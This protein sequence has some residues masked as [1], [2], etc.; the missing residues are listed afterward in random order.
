MRE[1]LQIAGKLRKNVI[2][3][4]C[5][6]L[7]YRAAV[8]VFIIQGARLAFNYSLK[9]MGYSYLT[10]ENYAVFIKNP[11]TMGIIFLCAAV[12]LLL[13]FFELCVI[14]NS[15]LCGYEGQ[16]RRI[17][18]LCFDGMRICWEQLQG[19]PA[20]CIVVSAM[21]SIFACSSFHDPGDYGN[22]GAEICGGTD[23]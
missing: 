16:S 8:A 7:M 22:Q 1:Y 11:L 18:R 5:F 9:R 19:A 12:I 17:R 14:V 6:E 3:L 4:L 21:T 2:N 15:C 20:F 13:L 10:A 23:L